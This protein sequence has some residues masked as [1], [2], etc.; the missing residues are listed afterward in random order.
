MTTILLVPKISKLLKI[1]YHHRLKRISN[2]IVSNNLYQKEES[3]LRL[4]R[5]KIKRKK[6]M[7][8]MMTTTMMIS[9]RTFLLMSSKLN[10]PVNNLRVIEFQI[11]LHHPRRKSNIDHEQVL[12]SFTKSRTIN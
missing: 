5:R 7:M 6:K 1:I 12:I 10:R 8:V 9:L 11:S 2:W 4:K 3:W